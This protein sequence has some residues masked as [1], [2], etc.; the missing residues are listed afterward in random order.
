M[1]HIQE[2]VEGWEKENIMSREERAM[3]RAEKKAAKEAA[4]NPT[5]ESTFTEEFIGKCDPKKMGAVAGL[6][7]LLY[8]GEIALN[9]IKSE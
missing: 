8:L 3:K 1:T 9:I 7:V 4:K 2:C 6:S 5:T